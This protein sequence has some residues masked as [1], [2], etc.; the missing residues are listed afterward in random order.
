VKRVVA[1]TTVATPVVATTTT[2]AT[3]VAG[4]PMIAVLALAADRRILTQPAPVLPRFRLL[5]LPIRMLGLPNL[6]K[7]SALALFAKHFVR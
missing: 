7:W 2:A 5:R 6:A 3:P 1:V 4:V